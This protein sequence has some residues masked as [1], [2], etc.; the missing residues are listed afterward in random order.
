MCSYS[1]GRCELLSTISFKGEFFAF[2]RA[3]SIDK[4]NGL[5]PRAMIGCPLHQLDVDHKRRFKP[6]VPE[7][8]TAYGATIGFE[9]DGNKFVDYYQTRGWKIKDKVMADWKAA[10][11]TWKTRHNSKTQGGKPVQGGK[12]VV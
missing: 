2:C 7:E 8:V 6:P 3:T 5:Y 1:S 10:V 4:V 12:F 11:R 9:I